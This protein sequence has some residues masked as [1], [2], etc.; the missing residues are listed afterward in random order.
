VFLALLAIFVGVISAYASLFFL[1][2][3][4]YLHLL[5]VGANGSALYAF[6]ENAPVWHL[7]FIPVIGAVIVCM[8]IQY[9]MPG[10]PADVIAAARIGRGWL[11]GVFRSFEANSRSIQRKGSENPASQNRPQ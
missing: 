3:V 8:I 1:W 7:F 4:D 11:S 2:A 9:G 10:G 6:L 5:L